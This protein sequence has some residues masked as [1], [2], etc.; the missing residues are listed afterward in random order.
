MAR[1]RAGTGRR[2]QAP[3]GTRA[4]Q[5]KERDPDRHQAPG[6]A[7]D[8]RRA[9]GT[10]RVENP[11]GHPAAER[12]ADERRHDHRAGARARFAWREVLSHDKGIG[13][14]EE[15]RDRVERGEAVEGQEQRERGCLEH[16]AQQQ[17]AQSPDAVGDPARGEAAD[18]AEP[19]HQ[20]EHL[21]AARGGK[22]QIRAVRHHVHLGHGHR[23]AA[24]DPR[25]AQQPLQLVGREPERPLGV[26]RH[27]P[28]T[29][30]RRR[31]PG[32][33]GRLPSEGERKQRHC[34]QA[35]QAG[36]HVGR[37]PAGGVDEVLHQGRPHRACEV[38]AAHHDRH[39]DAAPAREP[40]ADVRDQRNKGA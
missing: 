4:K 24:R 2:G 32:D 40:Q 28:R 37:A 1:L 16:G 9:V 26:R 34:E 39:R 10:G 31:K 38:V 29:R 3:T 18:D 6:D 11:S 23:D 22:A 8:E 30:T 17:R 14:H 20:R 25:H 35:D 12:H 36:P 21:G 33:R 5:E 13:R 19:H 15:R 27:S 7:V